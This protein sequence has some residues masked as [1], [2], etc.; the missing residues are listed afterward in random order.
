MGSVRCA[1]ILAIA[2]VACRAEPEI[3]PPT[4]ETKLT[5]SEPPT[6]VAASVAPSASAPAA[7]P[8]HPRVAHVLVALCDN[9]HQGIA[10]VPAYMG[11]GKDPDANLYWGAGHGLARFLA[12]SPRWRAVPVKDVTPRPKHVL[13]R[14]AFAL[15]D[16]APPLYLVADAYDGETIRRTVEDLYRAA[17]GFPG[18]KVELAEPG[19]AR[20]LALGGDADFVGYVGH[21]GLMD[22][23]VPTLTA[24]PKR[25][26]TPAATVLA[27]KSHEYFAAPL[28]K[29]GAVPYL[30][31]QDFLGPEGYTVDAVVA[32]WA[33]GKSSAVARDETGDALARHVKSLR[34]GPARRIFY[35]E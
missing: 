19:G 9:E 15:V 25:T 26:K 21:N 29:M 20:T 6:L 22:F 5:A 31:T 4:A 12:R 11:N 27:C 18:P 1:A 17:A 28:R 30:T 35:A 23:D 7:P 10:P 24:N 14:V 3:A 32:A 13:R 33:A 16:A 2:L 34:V 8:P